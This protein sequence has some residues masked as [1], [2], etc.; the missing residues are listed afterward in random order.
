ML[1]VSYPEIDFANRWCWQQFGPAEGECHQAHSEYPACNLPPPHQHQ[2]RWLSHFLVKT[3]YDF[4]YNEWYFTN[5]TD[6]DRF[7]EFI[8]HMH[9]GERYL[10]E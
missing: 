5:E 8:P 3:E 10:K 2:G 4:G 1:Q 6:R 7:V 9:W